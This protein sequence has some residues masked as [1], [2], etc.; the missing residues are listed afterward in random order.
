MDR[1]ILPGR[2]FQVDSYSRDT[3]LATIGKDNFKHPVF[4]AILA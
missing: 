3:E 2:H 4:R 1:H